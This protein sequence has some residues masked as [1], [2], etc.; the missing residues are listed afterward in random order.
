MVKVRPVIVISPSFSE[1]KNLVTIIPLSTTPPNK[2]MPYHYKISL[3]G[4]LPHPL[5]KECWVK[6]DMISTVSLS[7]LDLY[8]FPRGPN[9]K[10]VYYT[11]KL[12]SAQITTIE[13][14]I[15]HSLGIRP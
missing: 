12:D 9:G 2:V 7:R 6:G 14:C 8:R 13:Q 10:R 11:E 1:R 4:T 15:M 5:E 3:P